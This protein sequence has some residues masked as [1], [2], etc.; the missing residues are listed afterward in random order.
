MV[1]DSPTNWFVLQKAD[2]TGEPV[3]ESALHISKKLSPVAH[4]GPNRYSLSPA[5][6]NLT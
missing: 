5:T 1:C 3:S 6:A 4:G 2:K